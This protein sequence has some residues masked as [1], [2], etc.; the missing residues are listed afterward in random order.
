M[1]SNIIPRLSIKIRMVETGMIIIMVVVVI[2][3]TSV[4]AVAISANAETVA[5]SSS[6]IV[7]VVGHDESNDLTA[8]YV[9]PVALACR[10]L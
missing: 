8:L 2:M 7:P 6:S 1:T 4:I 9:G 3:V 10:P 5:G